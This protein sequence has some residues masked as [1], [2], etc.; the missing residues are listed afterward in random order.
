MAGAA[1]T[2]QA[3]LWVDLNADDYM[4]F[5]VYAYQ[6]PVL[7]RRRYAGHLRFAALLAAGLFALMLWRGREGPGLDWAQWLPLY[8][9]ALAAGWLLMFLFA[10]AYEKFL[11]RLVQARTRRMLKRQPVALFTG[12]HR[13]EFGPQGIDDNSGEACGRLPWSAVSAVEETA[14]YWFV[15]SGAMQG[16]ALPKRGQDMATLEAVGACLQTYAAVPV[17]RAHSGV[18]TPLS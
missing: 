5:T 13:V 12:R 3:T 10:L 11:P 15:F 2:E 1:R 18:S 14:G 8:F 7:R 16:L 17:S 4:A 6:R 9:E